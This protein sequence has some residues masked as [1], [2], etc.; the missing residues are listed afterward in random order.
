[1]AAFTREC[2]HPSGAQTQ[3]AA[4]A[5][6]MIY[7]LFF[8]SKYTLKDLLD[9]RSHFGRFALYMAI[10]KE[11]TL[12]FPGHEDRLNAVFMKYR[13]VSILELSLLLCKYRKIEFVPEILPVFTLYKV[14]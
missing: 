12:F 4:G 6:E 10:D 2:S 1:M 14:F 13:K 5:L 9:Q 3:F 11:I 8:Y 7:S